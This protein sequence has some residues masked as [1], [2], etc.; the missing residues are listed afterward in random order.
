MDPH[1]FYPHPLP[2]PIPDSFPLPQNHSA[3]NTPFSLLGYKPAEAAETL[4]LQGQNALLQGDLTK[5]MDFFE[6]ASQL[7][8]SNA[9]LHYA[10]GLSLYNYG[11]EAGREKILLLAGKKFKQ[12]TA[13]VDDYLPAWQAWG[14]ALCTLG[15]AQQETHYF[16][17][18][19]AR[20]SKALSLGDDPQK[21]ADADLFDLHRDYATA[22]FAL[23]KQS[24]EAIDLQEAIDSFEKASRY[25][26]DVCPL[27][28]HDF[29]SCYLELASK[30]NQ[31]RFC[32]QAVHCFKQA[33][34]LAPSSAL[35]WQ[36]LAEGFSHLHQLSHDEDHLTQAEEHLL[37]AH[38]IEP[39]T[40]GILIDL[41]NL[42]LTSLLK[43]PDSKKLQQCLDSCKKALKID[44]SSP[45]AKALY[46]QGLAM[47]GE[48]T[49]QV[50][51][52]QEALQKAGELTEENPDD[53]L[54]WFAH[55][56]C[57][58]QLAIYFRDVDYCYQ[59][60][61]KF[62]EGLSIDRTCQNHWHQ[63]GEC[64]SLL[65]EW[66]EDEELLELALHFFQKATAQRFDTYC[67]IQY[68]ITLFRLGEM[69]DKEEYV[70]QAL[71]EFE[72]VLQ[73]QKNAIYLHP[74]W[75]Y[76]Y[77]CALDVAGD[78]HEE[79]SCY[80]RAIEIFSHILLIDP[81]FYQVHHRLGQALAHLGDLVGEEKHFHR[82]IH[83]FRLSLKQ[84]EDNDH[85]LI[86]W[87]LSLI[88][89]SQFLHDPAEIQ[90]ML[91][92]AEHKLLTAI[93]LGNRQSYYYLSGLYSL[94]KSYDLAMHCLENARNYRALPPLEEILQDE[95][96]DNLRTTGNFREFLFDL[97]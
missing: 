53:P 76:H 44:P 72:Q 55:G 33:L 71:Q 57:L 12:A 11:R 25:S 52:L 66:E 32:M 46:V 13:L 2:Y 70:E 94:G 51:C 77:A 28:W 6:R 82:A 95:W 87:A 75:L 30:V 15:Q 42:L 96:L 18:A 1:T 23:G 20:L 47:L 16:Q 43:Q 48:T 56:I 49:E 73:L 8:P 21:L 9:H 37:T 14:S 93:K 90:Q 38:T 29:G 24:G 7:D 39:N 41:G 80:V 91:Q 40:I 35:N 34:S 79:E 50:E 10:Q 67:W 83:H 26:A 64:Y 3:A 65:A 78:F 63:I 58:K 36:K 4:L 84:E 81:Q 89:L 54:L 86:D 68:A 85:V 22:C 97:E 5:G 61:E 31:A 19:K 45:E 27:F 92:D 62:Q 59:A 17:E 69:T 60:I 88:H 74:D